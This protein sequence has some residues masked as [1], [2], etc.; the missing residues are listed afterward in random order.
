MK[1]LYEKEGGPNKEAITKLSWNY[2]KFDS[3]G[4]YHL[5]LHAIAKEINGTFLADKVV[6]NPATK[7]KMPFKKGQQVPSF[8]FLQDDGSTSSGDWVYCGI[9]HRR[10]QHVRTARQGRPHGHGPLP[11]VGLVLAGQPPDHLQR[12]LGNPDTG[13]PWDPNRPVIKWD[14]AKWTGDVPDGVG[15]P[16]SGRGPFIMKPDGVASLF[17][18]GLADGPFPEHYEP[19]ECPVEKNLL[20]P[21]FNNP[22][23]KRWEKKGVGTDTDWIPSPPATRASPSSA[24]PTA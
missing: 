19:M 11:P 1:A 24:P 18:P 6:E 23:V 5:D 22:V 16:G 15:D 20:S 7:E 4:H 8:A 9:L 17:G 3:K 2:G 13:K 21:Q 10:G 12:R 14:G